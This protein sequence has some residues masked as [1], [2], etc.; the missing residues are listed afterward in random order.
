MVAK[1]ERNA[2][3]RL[4]MSFPIGKRE[5]H[6][7]DAELSNVLYELNKIMKHI[8]YSGDWSGSSNGFKAEITEVTG[9]ELPKKQQFEVLVRPLHW[10]KEDWIFLIVRPTKIYNNFENSNPLQDCLWE[11]TEG[12]I[13]DNYLGIFNN[14]SFVVEDNF[15]IINIM[16]KDKNT[17][18]GKTFLEAK[19]KL[20]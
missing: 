5:V 1:I 6:K 14:F 2:Q 13:V 19:R 3:R 16:P 15:G 7:F 12:K 9:N 20:I 10:T 4:F 11:V 8:P 17:E 18:E